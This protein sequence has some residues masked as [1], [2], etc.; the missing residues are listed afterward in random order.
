M[1][2]KFYFHNLV[3]FKEKI[4]NLQFTT[5]YFAGFNYVPNLIV[6]LFNFCTLYLLWDLIV[7]VVL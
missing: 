1:T 5:M 2:R 3:K 7:R 4:V 6:I